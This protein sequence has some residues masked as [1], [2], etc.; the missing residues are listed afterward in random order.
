MRRHVKEILSEAKEQLDRGERTVDSLAALCEQ[1]THSGPALEST[2]VSTS[3]RADPAPAPLQLPPLIST[4]SR[5]RSA[6]EHH[7]RE[8]SQ[9]TQASQRQTPSVPS[10]DRPRSTPTPQAQVNRTPHTQAS[11]HRSQQSTSRDSSP[12]RP[13]PSLDALES[14]GSSSG[15]EPLPPVTPLISP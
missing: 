2:Q 6:V 5:P 14:S 7:S 9:P 11:R 15:E 13:R 4:G 12:S 8:P 1:M 10:N 3:C